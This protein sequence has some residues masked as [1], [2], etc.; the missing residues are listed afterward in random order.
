M[1]FRKGNQ[2]N[3]SRSGRKLPTSGW[4]E[5]ACVN[6]KNEATL[7]GDKN[8]FVRPTSNLGD[9]YANRFSGSTAHLLWVATPEAVTF[10]DDF[11]DYFSFP[12]EE[13]TYLFS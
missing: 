3:F 13:K 8:W 10:S 11:S 9:D 1:H 4:L 5:E 2:S 12:T 7:I 6:G